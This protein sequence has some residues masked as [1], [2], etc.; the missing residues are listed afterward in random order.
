VSS[1]RRRH[2]LSP[3]AAL[4]A[5]LV[6]LGQASTLL[7]EAA[8]PHVTCLEHGERVHLEHPSGVRIRALVVAPSADVLAVDA[9]PSESAEH[10]HEHC[11]LQG[12]RSTTTPTDA[13]DFLTA[14]ATALVR[15]S[16]PRV[17]ATPWLLRL[18]PKTSPPRAPIA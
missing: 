10:A 9:A 15:P 1:L 12:P 6:L 3:S 13:R 14:P 2:R 5:A 11:G 8:T 17:S 18:A 7:H 4:V 16:V